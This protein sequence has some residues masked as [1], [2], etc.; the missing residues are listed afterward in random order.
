M[1]YATL[2]EYDTAIARTQTLLERITLLGQSRSTTIAGNTHFTTEASFKDAEKLLN[3][4]RKERA[5]IDPNDTST[6]GLVLG[7]SW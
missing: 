1:L 6:G 4:L 5:M 7:A 3:K 2:A